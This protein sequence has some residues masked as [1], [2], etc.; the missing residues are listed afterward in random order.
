MEIKLTVKDPV[1]LHARPASILVQEATKFE[2]EVSISANGK[3]ANLKSIMS[4]MSLGVKT[5]EEITIK[6]DGADAEAAIAAIE[7][8][9]K[10][11]DLA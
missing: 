1:G 2:S 8:A 11:A 4:V 5:G 7:A 6:A 10:N 9:A 3:D